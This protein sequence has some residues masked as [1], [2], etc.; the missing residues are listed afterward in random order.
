ML[1]LLV[2]EP[3]ANYSKG[4]EIIDAATVQAILAGD[5]AGHVISVQ[6]PD[7]PA[8]TKSTK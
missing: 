7:A 6:A 8:S 5:N 3:F 2:T 1:K 4:D